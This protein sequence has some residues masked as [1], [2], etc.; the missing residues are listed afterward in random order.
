MDYLGIDICQHKL[1]LSSTNDKMLNTIQIELHDKPVLPSVILPI[2]A[3]EKIQLD[4]ESQNHRRGIGLLW[5]PESQVPVNGQSGLGVGRVPLVAAVAK[6]HAEGL[7]NPWKS[8]LTSS[9]EWRPQ[10]DII[11]AEADRI[12][13]TAVAKY[14]NKKKGT[15]LVIPEGFTEGAQQALLDECDIEGMENVRLIPRSIAIA[16]QWC[17]ENA[18][19]YQNVGIEDEEGEHLGYL[20]TASL[21]MD[22][23]EVNIVEIRSRLLNGKTWLIP[24]HDPSVGH[25]SIDLCGITLCSS[26]IPVANEL[27]LW[28]DLHSSNRFDELLKS[29]DPDLY[30]EES[31]NEYLF[32]YHSTNIP[33][34]E[35]DVMQGFTDL[36]KHIKSNLNLTE[37]ISALINKQMD[38]YKISSNNIIGTSIAGCFASIIIDDKPIGESLFSQ[39]KN[40]DILTIGGADYISQGASKA[41]YCISEGLPS[42]RAKLI[43]IDIYT[44]GKNALKDNIERW[45]PLVKAETVEAGKEYRPLKPLEGL[46]IPEGAEALTLILR[47]PNDN[48]YLYREV[49]AIIRGKVE[50]R[51]D[52]LLSVALKPGQGFSRVKVKSIKSGLVDSDLDWRTMKEKDTLPE[53]KL[54]YIPKVS[55]VEYYPPMLVK[56]VPIFEKVL[57]DFKR[58][59]VVKSNLDLLR[60]E[61]AKTYLA[62]EIIRNNYF[63]DKI[64][65][66]KGDELFKYA[67]VLNSSNSREYPIS[68]QALIDTFIKGLIE[69][70]EISEDP[71]KYLLL[72][73][74]CWLYSSAPEELL[75]F[76]K[77]KLQS[78]KFQK[79]VLYSAGLCFST[80]KELLLFYEK[81][82][83]I[84]KTRPDGINEWLRTFR[85]IVQF[86]EHA[87]S[88]DYILVE[89]LYEILDAIL[90]IFEAQINRNN[91]QTTLNNCLRSCLFILKRRRYEKGFLDVSLP[92]AQTENVNTK[93]EKFV[94]RLK[95]ALTETKKKHRIKKYKLFAEAT[96]NFLYKKETAE[97]YLRVLN[98]E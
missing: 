21:G 18:Q 42:Y 53:I 67:G 58:G 29:I 96:L 20:L 84:C 16:I 12:V 2:H 14:S 86:Q 62:N 76:T 78:G 63:S 59:E 88:D 5:P 72:N 34:E 15:A 23:W 46:F 70:F 98:D 13:A 94:K 92:S 41:A 95:E 69:I 4:I 51:E 28:R 80:D 1:C 56:A 55:Y 17:S 74:S 64:D 81:F 50:N 22:N 97:D 79:Q 31:L 65:I 39:S 8:Q 73:I 77:K 49:K 89:D 61:L 32:G 91:F 24:I 54:G 52:V 19:N 48:D 60:N 7:E 37:Q 35:L 57:R 71:E 90:T 25:F 26:A 45:V 9:F 40:L 47:R 93:D 66:P 85:N 43:P 30:D 3:K 38:K 11:S 82:H 68:E 36:Q 75:L 87:L 10:G 44:I 33:W 83:N 27:E 6:M